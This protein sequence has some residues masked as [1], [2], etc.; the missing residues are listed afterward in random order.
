MSA[1]HLHVHVMTNQKANPEE[2]LSLQEAIYLSANLL[3][4]NWVSEGIWNQKL[5]LNFL[6]LVQLR[7]AVSVMTKTLGL[8][9]YTFLN[10]CLSQ[11]ICVTSS[12]TGCRYVHPVNLAWQCREQSA[13][14][15]YSES[16]Y[17]VRYLPQYIDIC[18]YISYIRRE[19][20]SV[21]LLTGLNSVKM[22]SS[23][24]LQ[25][26]CQSRPPVMPLSWLTFKMYEFYLLLH[27][28]LCLLL[29]CI[30]VRLVMSCRR[31]VLAAWL[32]LICTDTTH[33]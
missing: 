20:W 3:I 11:P 1:V 5:L 24:Q 10:W 26:P 28:L 16:T 19:F 32:D 9:S 33:S 21:L 31:I 4:R 8:T 13:C 15:E 17:N 23:I 27:V 7:V 18:V 12:G 6:V 22:F 25:A 2:H 29:L 14:S 30:T